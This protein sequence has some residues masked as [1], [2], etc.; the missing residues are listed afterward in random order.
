MK[1][2]KVN[3]MMMNLTEK[4]WKW[5]WLSFLSQRGSPKSRRHRPTTAGGRAGGRGDAPG[6]GRWAARLRAR[7]AAEGDPRQGSGSLRPGWGQRIHCSPAKRAGSNAA[8]A[9]PAEG[10]PAG[11]ALGAGLASMW[12]GKGRAMA[13]AMVSG[14]SRVRVR[15][16]RRRFGLGQRLL[17]GVQTGADHSP[18]PPAVPTLDATPGAVGDVGPRG[19]GRGRAARATVAQ[20]YI[21]KKVTCRG[22]GLRE[23]WCAKMASKTKNQKVQKKKKLRS[24]LF[25]RV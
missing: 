15:R 23:Y 6:V 21:L 24:I 19:V 12:R 5:G 2:Y 4:G 16:L 11:A 14:G 25:I 10:P 22:T 13:T 9:S 20:I 7:V 3:L 17:R 18:D 8:T 1:L